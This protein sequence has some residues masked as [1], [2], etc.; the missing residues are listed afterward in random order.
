MRELRASSDKK[1]PICRSIISSPTQW[2]L[3]DSLADD[4]E[5][6]EILL[7]IDAKNSLFPTLFVTFNDANKVR[8]PRRMLAACE[9]YLK[10]EKL[11]ATLDRALCL[12]NNSTGS[13]AGIELADFWLNKCLDEHESCQKISTV[14]STSWLPTRLIDVADNNIRLIETR[15]AIKDG[16]D[17]RYVSLSH[18][19]GKIFIIRTL[20]ENYEEHKKSIDPEKLS[21]TFREAIH[22]TRKLGFRYIWIDSLCILQDSKSDWEAEAATMCDVYRHAVLKIAAASA[23]GGDIGC[24]QDRDGLLQFPF[25]VDLPSDNTNPR[26]LLFTSYGRTQNAS[27]PS[28]E[29][30]LY[31]R[32]WVLQEQLLS[33]RML[34]FDGL[35]LR[36]ECNHGS[37]RTPLGGLSRHIGNQKVVRAGIF[38]DEEF[39]D[40]ADM[41]DHELA[42]RYQLQYWVH[43]VMDY[44]HRGMTKASDRL[45]AIE[46]IAQALSRHT[47]KQYYAGIWSQDFWLGLLWSISHTNEYTP[48]T[49]DAFDLEINE[50][51]RHEQDIAPS[52]SWVSVTVP[53]VYPVPDII[54]I[55]RICDILS[56]SVNGTPA[57]KTGTIEI[58]GHLRTGY[59][60]AIYPYAIRDAARA[61]PHMTA[62][63]P[64]GI[65]EV[66]SYRGRAFHP[67]DYFI[68]SDTSPDAPVNRVSG[69]KNWRLVRGYFRPDEVIAPN[70]RLTFIAIAQWNVGVDPPSLTRKHRAND[71]LQ[72]WSLVLVATDE[73]K[74]QYRRK[75]KL[76]FAACKDF[77][78]SEV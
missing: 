70:T 61:V 78:V 66:I 3:R 72:V 7:E 52:W 15:E 17:R 35:Q 6:L 37:E 29:P 76:N 40:M 18:C 47:D 33:P 67:N 54:F 14:T 21:K 10:D 50:H 22:V 65:K 11:G 5:A 55:N 32:S 49:A 60:D 45:V 74:N 39:F 48:T 25:L 42:A 1:C 38:N 31:G 28:V 30:P 64:K 16:E 57:S 59:V 62:R 23:S 41:T 34:I 9:G 73:A 46:G 53:V 19:W 71:P 63:K 77:S 24:F 75:Y 8:L 56:V 13:D 36:W 68:F 51:V 43:T 58:S 12:D 20:L 44:T 2:E 27:G 69:G 26:R 4:E